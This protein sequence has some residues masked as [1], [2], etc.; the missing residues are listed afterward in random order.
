MTTFKVWIRGVGE[1]SWATNAR[2]FDTVAEARA[3][4]RDLLWRWTGA[5]EFTVL[6][7][8]PEFKGFLST[9]T[10]LEN[11]IKFVPGKEV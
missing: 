3:W 10:V 9:E 4:G 6:P 11:E 5:S 8:S 1:T 2:E 7:N